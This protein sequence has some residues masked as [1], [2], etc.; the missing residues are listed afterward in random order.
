MNGIFKIQKFKSS[1]EACFLLR[2]ILKLLW[3]GTGDIC[4]NKFFQITEN[5][6]TKHLTS[7]T[8][9]TMIMQC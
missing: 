1:I 4:F 7:A 8:I 9:K 3:L 5:K 6:N 2:A